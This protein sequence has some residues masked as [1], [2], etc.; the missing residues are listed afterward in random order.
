MAAR[1][2]CLSA[3]APH[4]GVGCLPEL[5]ILGGGAKLEDMSKALEEV[6]RD[7]IQL[8]RQQRLALARFLIEMDESSVEQGVEAMW[9]AEIEA[10]V[11]AV[12]EGRSEGIPYE[13]VISRIDE[14]LA[15]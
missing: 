11:R 6:S 3:A 1:R 4:F 12:D 10:R 2:S 13:Q 7:A 15:T 9:E 5:D 14:R 8:P